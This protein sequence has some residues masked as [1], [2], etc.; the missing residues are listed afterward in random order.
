MTTIFIWLVIILGVIAL[1]Q[2][3]KVFELSSELRGGKT[4]EVTPSDNRFNGNMMIIFLI[5]FFGFCLYQVLAWGEFLLPEPASEHGVDVDNLMNFNLIIIGTV[6]IITHILLFVFAYKYQRRPGQK[7]AFFA[8]SNK[9]ELIWTSVPAIVLAIIIIYGL[10]TW[11]RI[12]TP[13][14]DD[15]LLIELY[16]KQFDWT[17]RYAGADGVLG[18]GDV[19]RIDGANALGLDS[20]EVASH[21]DIIVKGEFYIPLDREVNFQFRS[22]DVIHSALFPHFRAQMN[23]VPGMKTY[24][25]FKPTITTEQMREKT[26]NPEFDYILLCNKI[27]GAAHYNMQMTIKVVEEAEY[28]AWLA[29]QAPFISGGS[30]STGST[31]TTGVQ[32]TATSV[33]GSET[34]A[35]AVKDTVNQ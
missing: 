8:H 32:A 30:G 20:S 16:S 35:T 9:L 23:T 27:C 29:Q 12:T 25:H 2:L 11:N 4:E 13:A 31:S 10:T 34:S 28:N 1:G 21:D 22:Q 5:A 3:L 6:F 7:A 24:F 19:R 17:A 18:E 14:G 15:A 33:T 26:G